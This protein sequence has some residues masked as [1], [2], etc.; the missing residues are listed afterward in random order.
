[1]ITRSEFLRYMTIYQKEVT[2]YDKLFD[3]CHENKDI[4]GDAEFTLPESVNSI[5]ELLEIAMELPYDGSGYTTLAFWAYESDFG[6][7]AKPGWLTNAK[8][9]KDHKYFSPDLSTLDKLYDY[10]LFEKEHYKEFLPT[11]LVHTNTLCV[12]ERF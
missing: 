11:D 6:K 8:L 4:C 3:L 2:F 5:I 9:P 12:H 10:L 1:M 7:R